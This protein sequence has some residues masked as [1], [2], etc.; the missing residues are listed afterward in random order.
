MPASMLH[1]GISYMP[2]ALLPL[3]R[4]AC[5]GFFRPKNPTAS[6]GCE[7]ANLGTKCHHATSRPP[8]PLHL[9]L[10][11]NTVYF[12]KWWSAFRIIL[13]PPSLGEQP[14]FQRNPSPPSAILKSHLSVLSGQQ[15][16]TAWKKPENLYFILQ[17]EYCTQGC[18]EI[19][20][21]VNT[22]C[23]MPES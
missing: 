8:K 16:S 3:R 11:Y 7:S 10:G 12:G 22:L 23:H 17:G 19:E 20:T 13:L 5:W 4:K 15:Y 2:T 14:T 6:A 9:L 1:L 18:Y 21:V